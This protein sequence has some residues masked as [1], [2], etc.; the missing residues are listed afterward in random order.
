MAIAMMGH[1]EQ[2]LNS[3]FSPS[4]EVLISQQKVIIY[5][6]QQAIISDISKENRKVDEGIQQELWNQ[7]S[8]LDKLL[9]SKTKEH[10]LSKEL[11]LMLK[12]GG[13]SC[14]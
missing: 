5:K 4:I 11:T 13:A 1:K 6:L 7:I 12:Q 3:S 2:E 10:H 8:C 14:Q 9:N